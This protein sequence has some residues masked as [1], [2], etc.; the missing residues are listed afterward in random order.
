M[1]KGKSVFLW[2]SCTLLTALQIIEKTFSNKLFMRKS[3]SPVP[4]PVV[5]LKLCPREICHPFSPAKKGSE[6]S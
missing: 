2:D 4:G 1:Y 5:L 6:L 3:H